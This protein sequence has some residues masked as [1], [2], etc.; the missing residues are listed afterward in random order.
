MEGEMRRPGKNFP[1][2]RRNP[3]NAVRHESRTR[4]PPKRPAYPAGGK[5]T[6]QRFSLIFRME[7]GDPRKLHFVPVQ[8]PIEKHTIDPQNQSFQPGRLSPVKSAGK[9]Q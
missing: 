8:P 3:G 6:P 2:Y 4:S 5:K 7:P 1:T 9:L